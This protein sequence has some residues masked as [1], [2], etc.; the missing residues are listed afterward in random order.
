[1]EKKG[2]DISYHQGNIDFEK[3][4]KDVDFVIIRCG[5][6]KDIASQDDKKFKRNI[7]ECIRLNIPFGIYLYSYAKSEAD[8]L[9]EANHVLRL[10]K[11]YKIPYPIYYDVEDASQSGLSNQTL[12]NICKTFCSTL[13]KNGYYTGIYANLSWLN[14]KLSSNELDKYD[15]W[16]AQ[17]AS[18]ATYKKSYGMWQYTSSGSVS[19]I[20]GRVDMNIVYK[21]YPSIIKSNK[22]NNYN[23]SNN[24]V[25][26][27]KTPNTNTSTTTKY[28]VVKGDSLWKIGEKY[29]IKWQDIAAKN[30]IK[31]PYTIR[32]GE[33]LDIPTNNKA[34]SDFKV[35]D[36][37]VFKSSKNIYTSVDSTKALKSK[38]DGGT[39]TKIFEGK[40][41]ELQL[42]TNRGYVR[43]SDVKKV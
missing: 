34:T 7:D 6:G 4:K 14:T 31:S 27:N 8:A 25:T 2:I 22:L 12:V 36:K 9:S 13:E 21:D 1:M 29:N 39:I 17:W 28:T 19:G 37:V 23:D 10:I 11:G 5:Y 30:N 33:V 41:N 38:Y 3:V 40:L 18:K 26:E 15:K 24:V 32:V 35:G 42:N 20:S 43:K 16:L